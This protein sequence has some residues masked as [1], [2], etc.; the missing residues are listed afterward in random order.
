VTSA[1]GVTTVTLTG[2]ITAGRFAGRLAE[3]TLVGVS[4][5]LTACL[6]TGITDHSFDSVLVVT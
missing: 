3:E 2:V 4:L 5:N 6:T 1:N